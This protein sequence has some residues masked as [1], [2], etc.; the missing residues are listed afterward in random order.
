MKYKRSFDISGHVIEERALRE[1]GRI[2]DE[3]MGPLD[4]HVEY[5]YTLGFSD[6]SSINGPDSSVLGQDAVTQKR[7]IEFKIRA[8][9][10]ELGRSIDLSLA[11]NK[12][13]IF[14]IMKPRCFV[15]VSAND[16]QWAKATYASIRDVV[17]HMKRQPRWKPL[18]LMSSPVVLLFTIGIFFDFT[19]FMRTKSLMFYPLLI[20]AT[21]LCFLAT[22]MWPPIEFNLGPDHLKTEQRWRKVVWWF[23]LIL[24][25]PVV[26]ELFA[27]STPEVP[28]TGSIP[29][30][31]SP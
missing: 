12:S 31:P 6:D 7:M 20:L 1:L 15:S 30:A 4:D 10:L 18:L 25:I 21:T 3:T 27:L 19:T 16:E 2:V 26:I 8:K 17:T 29:S 24:A 23:L 9:D 14:P 22:A 11:Q 5:R 13:Y 28:D